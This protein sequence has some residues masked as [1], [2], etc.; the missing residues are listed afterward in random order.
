MKILI[1]DGLS[2][3]GLNLLSSSEDIEVD[4]KKGL[5]PDELLQIIADYEGIVVRSA[6]KVTKDV[7]EASKGSLKIIGRAGIG[8]DNIDIDAATKHGVV[9]MNT[10]E[11]NAITTA[12]HAIT[13]MLSLARNIPQAHSSL[14]SG[15][16]ERNKFKGTE[17]YGKTIGFIGLGNIGKLVAERA[18]GL[19]MKAIAYDPFL[20]QESVSKLGVELVGLDEL[21]NEADVISIHTPLTADTKNLINK[22]TISSMKKGVMIVN[23]ARGGIV[24]EEDIADALTE[25]S[26]AGAAFD[27]YTQEPPA[28]DNPLLKL[29]DNIVLT[30]HLGA[31]TEEAQ[32]KVGIAMAEQIVDFA[33]SGVVRNAVNMPSLTA[34]QLASLK[35]FLNLAEKIGS[36]HGQICKGAVQEISINYEGEVSELDTEP[37]T[38]AALKGFLTP[39]MDVVVSYVNAPVIAKE[40]GIKIVESRSDESEDFN[41]LITITVRT[42]EGEN[43]VSG[44]IFGRQEPRFVKLNGVSIDVIPHGYLLISENYDK[45]GL[46]GSMTSLL[47]ERGVNIGLMHLGR[48]T[49]GGRAIVFTNV[50]SPVPPELIEEISKL[51]DIISVEQV[52]F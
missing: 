31:S 13:L 33:R 44:T 26:V 34:E 46:I 24:N 8:V 37:L 12:E 29:S 50:D 17:L 1:T 25:G 30:P 38:V 9:V 41:S 7:I 39:I 5:S 52:N 27:V 23:C 16:W 43:E 10:P 32:K 15:K 11:A 4:V 22:E 36:L 14:V 48:E 35:P 19:K 28:D 2:E 42:S 6:T 49:I 3:D 47:G 21:F 45:P 20:T 18:I 51:P 40:R